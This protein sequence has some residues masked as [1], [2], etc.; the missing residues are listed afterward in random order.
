MW[1]N[2]SVCGGRIWLQFFVSVW[3]DLWKSREWESTMMFYVPLMSYDYRDIL[4]LTSVHPSQRATELCDSAFTGSKD[5][6]CIQ[7]STLELSVNAKLCDPCTSCR[8]VM[9]M[10]T[11]D[12]ST[13]TRFNVSLR[14]HT[15]GILHHHA[16]P[17]SLYP[18][19]PYSRASD[20]SVTDG[21]TKT[22]LLIGTPLVV[23]C[24]RN[25]IHSWRSS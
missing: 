18:P 19:M 23:T 13:S 17:L 24:W 9:W 4:L 21:L 22:M 2:Y 10:V 16:R 12:D 8:M 7:P 20:H 15:E 11:D 3:S 1:N 14:C 25:F 6:L 5:A